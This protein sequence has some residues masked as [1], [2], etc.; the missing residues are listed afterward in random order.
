MPLIT[1]A[2]R[3]LPTTTK[4]RSQQ[5]TT[6]GSFSRRRS[7]AS[8][9]HANDAENA[10]LDPDDALLESLREAKGDSRRVAVLKGCSRQLLVASREQAAG[11]YVIPPFRQPHAALDLFG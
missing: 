8:N 6:T 10:G 3:A 9:H 11:V 5:T 2:H 1:K 4:A 7:L